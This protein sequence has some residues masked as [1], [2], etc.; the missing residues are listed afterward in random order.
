MNAN[1]RRLHLT[2]TCRSGASE[3]LEST[4]ELSKLVYYIT[5]HG[6]GH[7]VRSAD[8]IRAFAH[9]CPDVPIE[10][11][12][13]LPPAFLQNRLP[14]VAVQFR[15]GAFDVGM[16]QVDSVCINIGATLERAQN[17]RSNWEPLVDQEARL[18]E[19]RHAGLVVADIPAIPLQAAARAGIPGLAVANFGWDWIYQEY[20]ARDARWLPVVRAFASG[21]ATARL[22]LRLPL[23]EEMSSFPSVEDIPL[24][25]SPGVDRR[26]EIAGLTGCSPAHHWVLLS[27]TTLAWNTEAL[28]S[29]EAIPGYEFFTVLPL[30]WKRRNVHA[31][32]REQVPFM[33]IVAS[34]DTVISKPGYGIVS[35]CIINRKPLVYV[36]RSDFREYA[37]LEAGIKKCLR[38][39]HVS[40]EKLYSGDLLTSL[41]RVREAPDPPFS[42]P[43]G[44]ERVASA[45]ILGHGPWGLASS[46][47]Y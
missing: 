1:E 33:D 21:Y 6:Y 11:V 28:K 19:E 34:V 31:L 3:Q 2:G 22:L 8:I 12:T 29:V 36:D 44:G 25:S 9:S 10:I 32:D 35:D 47:Q 17:L 26:C 40:Q 4:R 24:V 27:F 18:L 43:A 5:A 20:A 15:R 14:G 45:R 46:D 38:N 42:M 37:V 30:E 41:E 39:V 16:V 7:G 23:H 13:D